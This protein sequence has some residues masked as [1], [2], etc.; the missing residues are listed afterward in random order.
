MA[1]VQLKFSVKNVG[2]VRSA[3]QNLWSKLPLIG[4]NR[5]KDFMTRLMTRMKIYPPQRPGQKYVRTYRLQRNWRMEKAGATGYR[6][7]N[8]T[9]YTKYVV[10]SAFGTGQAWMHAG[11]WTTLRDA[12]DIE[13][14]SL[15]AKLV[16]D[17]NMVA[18]RGGLNVK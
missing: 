8:R 12:A 14:A 3:L 17:I 2:K 16:K 7:L 5:I 1:G 13:L 9:P 10:G 15:P 11:R 6:L 4:G 18:R